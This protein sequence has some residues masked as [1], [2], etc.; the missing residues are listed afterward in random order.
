MK[1]KSLHLIVTLGSS[2]LFTGCCGNEYNHYVWESP[3]NVFQT[4][5]KH[6]NL[7][8]T[9]NTINGIDLNFGQAIQKEINGIGI[10]P[11][12]F[13]VQ[14]LRGMAFY[15]YSCPE[16]FLRIKGIALGIYGGS[17][18]TEGLHIGCINIIKSIKGCC[19]GIINVGP[20]FVPSSHRGHFLQ[21]G[22]VNS[23][24]SGGIQLG[25]VNYNAL[26][27]IPLMLFINYG[28]YSPSM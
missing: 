3:K 2:I 14:D 15:V 20:E 13:I 24:D 8:S 18:E 19:I 23:S 12:P 5:F 28:K 11:N 1:N 21:I 26:S 4:G 22:L 25:F 16:R 6:Y 7:Y 27:D 9:H 10:M 17:T